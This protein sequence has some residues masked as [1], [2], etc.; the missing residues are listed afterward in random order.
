MMMRVQKTNRRRLKNVRLNVWRGARRSRLRTGFLAAV[1]FACTTV[2]ATFSVTGTAAAQIYFPLAPGVSAEELFHAYDGAVLQLGIRS[3]GEVRAVTEGSVL[4]ARADMLEIQSASGLRI[5]YIGIQPQVRTGDTVEAGSTIGVSSDAAP[6]YVRIY[7]ERRGAWVDPLSI[8]PREID[9]R[10]VRARLI[11]F[12][13]FYPLAQQD[14]DAAA[15]Q[16]AA[17]KPAAQKEDSRVSVQGHPYEVRVI[18]RIMPAG[19]FRLH[20]TVQLADARSKRL[21]FP[22]TL[23]VGVDNRVFSFSQEELRAMAAASKNASENGADTEDFVS[24]E[25]ERISLLLRPIAVSSGYHTAFASV[26]SSVSPR[27]SY[28]FSFLSR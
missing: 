16:K 17:Q 26:R 24:I 23:T 1:L 28:R 20:V 18:Q 14:R 25:N 9:E 4:I 22:E 7:D 10:R 3:Y 5:A 27:S 19:S 12:E 8:L 11:D 6:W 13:F 15:E 21:V 2:V